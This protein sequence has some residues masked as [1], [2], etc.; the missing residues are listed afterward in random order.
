[1]GHSIFGEVFQVNRWH[2]PLD[3]YGDE[4]AYHP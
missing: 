2:L 3:Q 4:L 1:M